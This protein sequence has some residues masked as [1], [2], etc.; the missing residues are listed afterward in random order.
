MTH[1]LNC[2]VISVTSQQQHW[3]LNCYNRQQRFLG[4]AAYN[5]TY[6][7]IPYTLV[8]QKGFYPTTHFARSLLQDPESE[9]CLVKVK[10]LQH[11][12][13]AGSLPQQHY[14]GCFILFDAR[15]VR[16]TLL[17]KDDNADFP[18]RAS[19]C[20]R[21]D[22]LAVAAATTAARERQMSSQ[23]KAFQSILHQQDCHRCR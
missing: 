9:A 13:A 16:K 19:Y 1:H 8:H 3:D 7:L 20:K 15:A 23:R 18:L 12:A 2:V 17:Q 10:A 21:N 5:F 4:R 6:V 14:N 22:L 11:A